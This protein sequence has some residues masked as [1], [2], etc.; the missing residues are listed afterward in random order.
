M[1]TIKSLFWN[2]LDPGSIESF[3]CT[4]IPQKAPR[5]LSMILFGIYL[6][7]ASIILVNLLIA[8]IS[9]TMDNIQEKRVRL[10]EFNEGQDVCLSDRLRN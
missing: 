10:H 4:K 7:T 3:G 1:D 8:L 9:N 5:Y 6:V 2:L